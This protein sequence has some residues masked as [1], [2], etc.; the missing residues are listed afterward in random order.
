MMVVGRAIAVPVFLSH[1]GPWVTVAIF[2]GVCGGLTVAALGWE[3]L[4]GGS[5]GAAEK[6]A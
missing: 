2:E 5:K 6:R 1:G 4:N 3:S